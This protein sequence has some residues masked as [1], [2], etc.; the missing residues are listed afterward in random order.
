MSDNRRKRYNPGQRTRP[1]NGENNHRISSAPLRGSSRNNNSQ[2]SVSD[3]VFLGLQFL[4]RCKLVIFNGFFFLENALVIG[5]V[6]DIFS[7]GI[8]STRTQ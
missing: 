5:C 4:F 2:S 3:R 7:C 6:I 1:D 8:L